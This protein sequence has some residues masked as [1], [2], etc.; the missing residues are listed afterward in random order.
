MPKPKAMNFQHPVG[1]KPKNIWPTIRR[2]FF[3]MREDKILFFFI[4]A[5]IVCSSAAQVIG[6]ALLQHI[7]DN[8]ILPLTQNYS[9]E[10]EHGFIQ[11]LLYMG[12][13]Y[14]LGGAASYTYMR[15]MLSLSTKTLFKIRQDLFHKMESLSIRYFDQ[16]T[17]GELMSLYTNDTDTLREMLSNSVANFVAASLLLIGVFSTMLVF[18]WQL[19]VL[20]V[21]QLMAIFYCMKK[22]GGKS[23]L[24]FKQQQNALGQLNGFI[25]EIIDGQKVVKVFCH[26]EHALADFNKLNDDLC[27]V[28]TNANIFSNILMPIMSNIANIHYALTTILGSILAIYGSLSVGTVIAFLQLTRNF[29]MPITRISQQFNT[30]L[31]ALAGAERIFRLID[32]PPEEDHG[33]ITL[34]GSDDKRNTINSDTTCDL[35]LFH[36]KIPHKDGICTYQPLTGHIEFKNVFF[37]YKANQPVLKGI[38]LQAVRGQKIAFVGSTGAGKTTITNLINRFY[39]ITDGTILYDGI[40]IHKISKTSLRQSLSMVLQDTHLFTGTVMDNIRYGCLAASD[41]AVIHA[42]KLANADTF[43]K[44]LPHGYETDLTADGINLS[45]GQRQ[46]LAIARA[47]V[48]NTPVLIFDEATSSIDTR[49][50][51]LIDEGMQSLMQGKTVFIIAHRLSTVKNADMIMVLE[52]GTII[53]RGSHDE[54]IEKKGKY[55]QLYT[56]MFEL[57]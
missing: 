37:G 25:E 8:F 10:L 42:A 18:S 9:E 32:E 20:V 35:T 49:T 4:F 41:K 50:E 21:L 22:I 57:S 40:P 5:T 46:L 36:W 7:I 12:I 6:A 53:E 51:A 27:H 3:Y 29:S 43:I 28:S 30:M 56:G 33:S 34:T 54:L 44:H 26:E 14:G 13:I 16:H 39:D 31:S 52:Q 55:Y 15:L 19:T 2:I 48:A 17:H 38:S 24:Y 1:E 47:A 45:Q 11:T 23:R